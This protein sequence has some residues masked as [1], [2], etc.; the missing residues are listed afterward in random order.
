MYCL[1]LRYG[2]CYPSASVAYNRDTD[3]MYQ[4]S[5]GTRQTSLFEGQA[6]AWFHGE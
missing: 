1:S 3:N 2:F 4:A 6:A 5:F